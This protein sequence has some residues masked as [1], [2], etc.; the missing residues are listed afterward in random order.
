MGENMYL[1]TT[2]NSLERMYWNTEQLVVFGSN[3]RASMIG[4]HHGLM[5]HFKHDVL[6][7]GNTHCIAN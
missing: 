5:T 6:T 1:A 4:C 7:M 3:G 2:K